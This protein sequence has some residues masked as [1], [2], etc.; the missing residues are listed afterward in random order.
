MF[1]FP[2]FSFLLATHPHADLKKG[3][4]DGGLCALAAAGCGKNLTLLHL[5]S[6]NVFFFGTLLFSFECL[7]WGL[8]TGVGL[9]DVAVAE[10]LSSPCPFLAIN[11]T[12]I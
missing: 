4:T 10:A 1:S 5:G 9:S 3:V 8:R 6:E 7:V 12:Q 11:I 2:D